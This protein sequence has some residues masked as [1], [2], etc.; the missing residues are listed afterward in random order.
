MATD[1]F[2]TVTEESSGAKVGAE[3]AQKEEDIDNER[4]EPSNVD[5]SNEEQQP[6]TWDNEAIKLSEDNAGEE[7]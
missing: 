1:E 6:E 3:G 2:E 5:L 4:I 7:G